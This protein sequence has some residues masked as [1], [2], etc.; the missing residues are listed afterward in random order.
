MKILA[1]IRPDMLQFTTERTRTY[2]AAAKVIREKITPITAKMDFAGVHT[3]EN[4]AK[5]K[6]VKDAGMFFAN[7][8]PAKEKVAAR[9]DTSVDTPADAP[10]PTDVPKAGAGESPEDLRVRM[11]HELVGIRRDTFDKMWVDY[12]AHLTANTLWGEY[13]APAGLDR[14]VTDT[15][16]FLP[17]IPANPRAQ[18]HIGAPP[19]ADLYKI[20]PKFTE[21]ADAAELTRIPSASIDLCTCVHANVTVSDITPFLADG[22]TI[23]VLDYCFDDQSAGELIKFELMLRHVT[24][25]RWISPAQLPPPVWY[26]RDPVYPVFWG[27]YRIKK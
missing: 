27:V 3:N 23:C 11:L 7:Y 19:T 13:F 4:V 22:A 26:R 5:K 16:D 25:D 1:H 20:A 21:I 17:F 18:L 8:Y 2:I 15:M 6:K 12:Q 14:N 9:A 10:T 24:R